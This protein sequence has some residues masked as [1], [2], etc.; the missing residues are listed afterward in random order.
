MRHTI[1]PCLCSIAVFL[2]SDCFAQTT[3]PL[4]S[5][6]M[7]PQAAPAPQKSPPQALPRQSAPTS[8]E[9]WFCLFEDKRF[10]IGAG[11]CLSN[12]LLQSCN[13]PDKDH[14][15]SWWWVHARRYSAGAVAGA[16]TH[17]CLIRYLPMFMNGLSM[18]A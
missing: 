3:Q 8:A 2:A 17:L 7:A 15:S 5:P 14:P 11:V 9:A 16:L 4:P 18:S 1:L 10:S 12:Q 13:A 6:K